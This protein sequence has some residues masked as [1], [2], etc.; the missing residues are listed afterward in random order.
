MRDPFGRPLPR[1]FYARPVLAVARAV[2]G[3]VLVHDSTQGRAAGRIVEV[4]AYRGEQDPASHAYRGRSARNAVMFGPA[5]HAYVYFIYGAHWC[6]NL[7]TGEE[8]FASAVLVRALEPVT[9]L[10][11]MRARRGID[12]VRRLCRG[13]GNL[14]AALG[15]TRAQNGADLTRG[16]LWISDAPAR[17]A[18]RGV[19]RGPRIGISRAA[20]RPWRFWLTGHPGVSATRGAAVRAARLVHPRGVGR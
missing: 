20:E 2:L 5:G 12:D 9:G 3:R 18:G 16:P 11:L 13:P 8:G 10:E 15:I 6:L 19:A 7:V 14:A 4:E 1:A 17:R